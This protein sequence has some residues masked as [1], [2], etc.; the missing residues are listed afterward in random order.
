MSFL[1]SAR[2]DLKFCN[3]WETAWMLFNITSLIDRVGRRWLGDWLAF[4]FSL[5]C[6]RGGAICIVHCGRALNEYFWMW[7]TRPCILF[8]L[9]LCCYCSFSYLTVATTNLFLSEPM[10]LAFCVSFSQLHPITWGGENKGRW[11]WKREVYGFGESQWEN[12]GVPFLKQDYILIQ[13][14]KL[15]WSYKHYNL[16]VKT[17]QDFQDPYISG[18]LQSIPLS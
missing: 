4:S 13:F 6:G 5:K 9:I 8:L 12:L 1:V 18:Q 15:K 7:I 17:W 2:P 14:L 16:E 11:Q 10:I 3:T